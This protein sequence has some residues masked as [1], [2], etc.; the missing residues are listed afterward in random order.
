[1]IVPQAVSSEEYGATAK[2]PAYSIMNPN[3]FNRTFH[4]ELPD[5]QTQFLHCL[6]HI[7]T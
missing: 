4:Y 1:L 7:Q 2:R 6:N 5:W 3:K